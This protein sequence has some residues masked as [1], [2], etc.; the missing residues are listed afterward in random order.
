MIFSVRPEYFG[1]NLVFGN[2]KAI[3]VQA[4]TSPVVSSRLRL[5]DFKTIGT[6]K[7]YI[8]EKYAPAAF[9]PQE[10]FSVLISVRDDSNSGP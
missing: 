6:A 4:W 3:P 2:G 9:N 7:W 8:C 10:I 1:Y 5:P